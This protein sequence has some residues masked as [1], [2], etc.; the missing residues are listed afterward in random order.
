MTNYNKS[1]KIFKDRTQSQPITEDIRRPLQHRS[2]TAG[3]HRVNTYQC[4]TQTPY[5]RSHI[6][7]FSRVIRVD[8]FRGHVRSASSV[9]CPR[10]RVYQVTADTEITQLNVTLLIQ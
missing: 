2:K 6:I 3:T 10:Y 4:D 7:A 5:I 1:T 8:S 9:L